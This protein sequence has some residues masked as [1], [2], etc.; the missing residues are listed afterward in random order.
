[1]KFSPSPKGHIGLYE[2][3][4]GIEKFF[5][6]L[7]P[8]ILTYQASISAFIVDNTGINAQIVAGAISMLIYILQKARQ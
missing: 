2:V 5:I 8:Q 7:L 1:M 6:F 3:V 4:K